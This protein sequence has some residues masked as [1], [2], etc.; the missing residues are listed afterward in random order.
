MTGSCV[1]QAGP[2]QVHRAGCPAQDPAEGWTPQTTPQP[3]TELVVEAPLLLPVRARVARAWDVAVGDTPSPWSAAQP[4]MADLVR[5]AREAPWC[6]AEADGWR[7]AGQVYQWTVAIPI[8]LVTYL[9]AWVVQRP[10]RLGLAGLLG[11]L[12]V[13]AVLR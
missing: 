7:R 11:L 6:A 3:S 1:C 8:S 5:Y 4:P 12:V 9:V 2:G 13:L 10:A